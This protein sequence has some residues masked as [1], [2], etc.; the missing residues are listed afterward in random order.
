MDI[1]EENSDLEWVWRGIT[2]NPNLTINFIRKYENNFE[3]CWDIISRNKNIQMEDIENNLYLPWD[4]EFISNNTN[5][6][7]ATL[8]VTIDFALKYKNKMDWDWVFLNEKMT[9]EIIGLNPDLPWN[10]RYISSNPNLTINFIKKYPNK[11]WS[12]SIISCNSNITMEDIESH[13]EYAWDYK[14][15]SKNPNLTENF[16]NKYFDQDWNWDGISENPN[17]NFDIVQKHFNWSWDYFE[18]SRHPNIT[19]DIIESNPDLPW[20]WIGISYNKNL[21]QEFIRKNFSELDLYYISSQ[22]FT[23]KLNFLKKEYDKLIKYLCKEF[24]YQVSF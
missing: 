24:F 13:P 1:I 4:F 5:L 8:A 14:S 7:E 3:G 19:C 20:D 10:Y 16:I 17:I 6:S 9:L 12:W 21:T 23:N 22:L 15:I 11:D 18:L 2:E